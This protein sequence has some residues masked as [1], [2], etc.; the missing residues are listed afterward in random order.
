MIAG[1]LPLLSA[2]LLLSMTYRNSESLLHCMEQQR[3]RLSALY[4]SHG[5]GS[6]EGSIAAAMTLGARQQVSEELRHDYMVSGSS[7]VF[8]LSGMHLGILFM[9]LSLLLPLMDHPRP[10]A[11]VQLSAVWLYVL[12]VG[13][14]PS[15]LRASLMLSIYVALL[16]TRWKQHGFAL[17]TLSALL[18]LACHPQWLHDVGFQLSYAALSGILL[19]FPRLRRL[20]IHQHEYRYPDSVP[21]YLRH[22]LRCACHWLVDVSLVGISAQVAVT[23][24]LV[25]HFHRLSPYA[26]PSGIIVA[27]LLLV[28]M[29]LAPL[30]LV[31]CLSAQ[32]VPLVAAAATWCATALSAVVHAMNAFLSWVAHLPHASVEPLSLSLVRT[33]LIYLFL[34]AFLRL[35]VVRTK[36]D[37]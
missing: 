36:S 30:F 28:V 2:A 15:L 25:Y 18:L 19:L 26:I 29:L 3:G 9:L 14:H 20:V 5:I 35:L 31:L 37:S 4:K 7:H 12:L 22:W 8:A 10:C 1:M 27:P 11:L 23:P 34:L 13:P 33:L 24:L 17:L 16:Q 32:I 21:T 6:D